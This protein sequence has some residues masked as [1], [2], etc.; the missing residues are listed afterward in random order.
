MTKPDDRLKRD[1]EAELSWDPKVNAAE[2]GVSVNEGAVS[3]LGTVDTYAQKWAAEDATKRVA[4]V[5]TVAQDLTVKIQNEHKRSDTDIAEAIQS[6]LKWD[7]LVPKEVT[8]KV[9]NGMVTLEGQVTWHF[10]RESAERAVRNLTGVISISNS[11]T[12]KPETSVAQVKEKVEA[13]LQRQ[14]KADAKS[15][16]VD[17]SGGMVTL[18][19]YA[20]SWQSIEDAANAAWAPPGVTQVID[21]VK[22]Q[23]TI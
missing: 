12:M 20:S 2:I 14:A 1:I 16:H 6:A 18:T 7:V 21:Q 8:A 19:G 10:Q 15:I 3:L 17:L 5:R 23:M 13:A 4:G 22:M 9:H 11:I